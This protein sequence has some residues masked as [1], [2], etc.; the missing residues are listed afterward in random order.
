MIIPGVIMLYA[1]EDLGFQISDDKALKELKETSF[2]YLHP[3]E[4]FPCLLE[5]SE[6]IGNYHFV[7]LFVELPEINRA[8]LVI[9]PLHARS[10]KN[11][12]DKI[13]ANHNC[14]F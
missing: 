13:F 1:V 4:A 7:R 11:L 10:I 8:D 5:L 9:P 14:S 2:N 6:K 12:K 3:V